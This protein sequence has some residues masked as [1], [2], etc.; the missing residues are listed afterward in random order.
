M[1]QPVPNPPPGFDAL[2]VDEKIDYVE[3]LWGHVV[4]QSDLPIP[5]WQRELLQERL[6]AYRANPTAGRPWSEVR[7]ELERKFSAQRWSVPSL[8]VQPK[9]QADIDE[10]LAWYFPRNPSLVPR[11]LAELDSV[12]DR[13]TQNPAQF[14]VDA[15]RSVEPR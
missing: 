3:S 7:A 5:D 15:D 6:A 14:P 1:G 12:F 8:I 13:I 11:F 10:A 9:A 4:D 2:S